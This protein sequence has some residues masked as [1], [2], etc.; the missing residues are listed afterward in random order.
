[1]EDL[2]QKAKA[3]IVPPTDVPGKPSPSPYRYIRTYQI[4]NTSQQQ[5]PH[6]DDT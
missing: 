5:Q 4:E 2:M 1:M 3:T 6:R